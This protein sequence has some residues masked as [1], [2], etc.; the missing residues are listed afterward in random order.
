M[1]TREELIEAIEKYQQEE[2]TYQNCERILVFTL[3]LDRYYGNE[4]M[5][6]GYSSKMAQNRYSSESEFMKVAE[7][8]DESHLFAVL[9]DLFDTLRVLNPRLYES[10]MMKL[11][12]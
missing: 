9:D 10:C 7:K 4:P 2:P 8:I 12:N 6:A 3:M 11:K 1:P 5:V